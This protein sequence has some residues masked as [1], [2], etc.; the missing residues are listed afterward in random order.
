MMSDECNSQCPGSTEVITQILQIAIGAD[1]DV[2]KIIDQIADKLCASNWVPVVKC[3]VSEPD[4]GAI[5][6][7]NDGLMHGEE[8]SVEEAAKM[9]QVLN[10][11][12][13]SLACMCDCP[14]MLNL[15]KLVASRIYEDSLE[16]GNKIDPTAMIDRETCTYLPNLMPCFRTAASCM[17]AQNMLLQGVDLQILVTNCLALS[18]NCPASGQWW[19]DPWAKPEKPSDQTGMETCSSAARKRIL[20]SHPDQTKCCELAKAQMET[21]ADCMTFH[22]AMEQREAA[23]WSDA[24]PSL[25]LPTKSQVAEILCEA[26]SMTAATMTKS[27]CILRMVN[28]NYTLGTEAYPEGPSEDSCP[29][30]YLRVVNFEECGRIKHEVQWPHGGMVF[31]DKRVGEFRKEC[32]SHFTKGTGCFANKK[33]ALYFSECPAGFS[34]SQGKSGHV[35]V[36][37]ASKYKCIAGKEPIGH[38]QETR[39]TA[40]SEAQCADECGALSS[41]PC[42]AY[43]Y[44]AAQGASKGTCWLR[45]IHNNMTDM[46]GGKGCL[47]R[48]QWIEERKKEHMLRQHLLAE[49]QQ[50]LAE[51]SGDQQ[52]QSLDLEDESA[53][54]LQDDYADNAHSTC[55]LGHHIAA[56]AIVLY[57]A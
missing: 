33:G 14:L 38:S 53:K 36:C 40:V 47:L 19:M 9:Q 32:A 12:A 46:S 54:K 16:E 27:G 41:F 4:C 31:L 7:V 37:K 52:E 5:D 15:T 25:S 3:A 6:L 28:A 55:C 42:T 1:F 26:E 21:D 50:L 2:R 34:G 8:K 11:L 23:G 18:N 29:S 35:P 17:E 45:D 48:D 20:N 43:V 22:S 13:A 57:V 39:L 51:Q 10:G 49:Q 44:T 24:C 56:F 30:G